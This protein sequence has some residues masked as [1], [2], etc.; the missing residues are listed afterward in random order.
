MKEFHKGLLDTQHLCYI[1]QSLNLLSPSCMVAAVS[2]CFYPASRDS[3]TRVSSKC[4]GLPVT[5]LFWGWWK[6]DKGWSGSLVKI[7]KRNTTYLNHTPPWRVTHLRVLDILALLCQ[8]Q[9]RN[10]NEHQSHTNASFAKGC[11]TCLA[12][13]WNCK[14][15]KIST[16][17]P[18]KRLQ[19]PPETWRCFFAYFNFGA[20][21]L[22]LVSRMDFG[23]AITP[24]SP[25]MA[26]CK[27]TSYDS[28]RAPI[29]H[30][31]NAPRRFVFN[32]QA[33]LNSRK[34]CKSRSTNQ[35]VKK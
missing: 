23:V 30:S 32:T 27:G 24:F 17:S 29:L 12:E 19:F 31:T 14:F 2:I 10:P 21:L 25:S 9:C 16:L 11:R 7:F 28:E 1:F 13:N 3:K 20:V 6:G 26:G 15:Y 18:P 33:M 8:D 4:E 34:V 5:N 22:L 35:P